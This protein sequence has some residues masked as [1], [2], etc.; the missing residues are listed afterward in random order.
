MNLPEDLCK[1]VGIVRKMRTPN[2]NVGI[3]DHTCPIML[4]FRGGVTGATIILIIPISATELHIGA[5]RPFV[6]FFN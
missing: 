6:L 4:K 5:S 1:Y 2:I 3:V